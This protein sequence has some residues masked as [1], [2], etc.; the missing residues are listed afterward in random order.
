M[1]K[2]TANFTMEIDGEQVEDVDFGMEVDQ[3]D[4]LHA[5]QSSLLTS[6]LQYL[7]MLRR[8]QN[9]Q[10]MYDAQPDKDMPEMDVGF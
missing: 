10:H 5:H 2:L 3:E 4:D 6:V 7:K 1:A 9:I 8:V